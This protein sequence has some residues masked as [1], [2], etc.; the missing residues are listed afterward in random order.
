M[1]QNIILLPNIIFPTEGGATT[2]VSSIPADSGRLG[3]NHGI[4]LR[5]KYIGRNQIAQLIGELIHILFEYF[6]HMA[7]I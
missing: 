2:T 3:G 6:S 5:I 4:Y 1:V 7:Y